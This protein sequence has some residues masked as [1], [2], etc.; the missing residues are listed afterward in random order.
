[1]FNDVADEGVPKPESKALCMSK[2]DRNKI[3]SLVTERPLQN[4]FLLA[5]FAFLAGVGFA[6]TLGPGAFD[7]LPRALT[8]Y[9]T[10][11]SLVAT[12]IFGWAQVVALRRRG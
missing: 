1:M 8:I 3:A 6:A 9:A 11:A 7:R 2:V 5:C 10:L 4:V 12:V